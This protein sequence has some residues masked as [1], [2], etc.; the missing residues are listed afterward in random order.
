MTPDTALKSAE[1][2]RSC[3]LPDETTLYFRLR[4]ASTKSRTEER[5]IDP[6]HSVWP[7]SR[8]PE[9]RPR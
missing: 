7:I 8:P 6:D 3:L 1:E 5:E 2:A 4:N 9:A